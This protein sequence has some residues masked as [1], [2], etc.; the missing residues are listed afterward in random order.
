MP[1]AGMSIDRWAAVAEYDVVMVSDLRLTGGT[2]ASMAEEIRAQAAAGYRT[3]LVHVN[4]TLTSGVRGI[5]AHL[6]GMVD[7]GLADLALPGD[8]VRA[9]HAVVRHPRVAQEM[10]A[11]LREVEVEGVTLVANHPLRDGSGQRR[12][13]PMAVNRALA[14]SLGAEPTWRPV[15]PVVRRQLSEVDDLNVDARDWPG[16][17]DTDL[18]SVSRTGRVTGIPV[19]GRHGYPHPSK[20]P[21]R[22]EDILAAYPEVPDVDIRVLGGAEPVRHVLGRIPERWRVIGLDEQRPRDFL[23]ELDFFVYYHHPDWI[24]AYGRAIVEALATG[25]VAILPAH[26]QETYGDAAVYATPAEVRAVVARLSADPLAYREQSERGR[27]FVADRHGHAQ[28]RDRL[29]ELVGAPR[30]ASADARTAVP[31]RG[32]TVPL[33][34]PAGGRDRARVMFVSSNG[35]GMGHLTRL[36]AMA[37][38]ASSQIEPFFFSMS[39]AVSVVARHGYHWEYCPSRDDLDVTSKEWNPLFTDRLFDI[40]RRYQP[41][42]LVFDGTWPYR[43]LHTAREAFPEL[44]YVW[45]RRG[46]W[47]EGHRTDALATSSWF[48]LVIEPGEFAAAADRG[49]TVGRAEARKVGPVTLLDRPEILDRH[50]ARTELGIPADEQAILVALGGG[51]AN[52]LGP[53]VRAVAEAARNL[54][55]GDWQVYTTRAPIARRDGDLPDGVHALSVHP[56]AQYLTAFDLVVTASGYNS[57]HEAIMAAAP[58]IFVPMPKVT[59][60]QHARARYAEHVG[61]GRCVDELSTDGVGAALAQMVDPQ[62]RAEMQERCRRLYPD[63]GAA[64]AILLVE[65]LLA[66]RGVIR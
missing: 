57:Y 17:I 14:T 35:T 25:A 11:P 7:D 34:G 21:D 27:R 58:T 24:E 59:D 64:E 39:S 3:A 9:R 31:H 18:W 5:S 33:S 49:P 63:N 51:N 8:R 61:V 19:L 65:E 23:A 15:G 20:W 4:S 12:Y 66:K 6:R 56:L 48:D 55:A 54:G 60:D 16:V 38:R 53:G 32:P 50:A 29:V 42:A 44:V 2:T 43:G 47:V 1:T 37:R 13:D 40:V 22:A 62:V 26:F 28:H 46:M 30:S 10:T 41:R 45:S 36:L 52:D